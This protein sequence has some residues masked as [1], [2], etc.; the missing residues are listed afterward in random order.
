MI[1]TNDKNNCDYGIMSVS[2]FGPSYHCK[3]FSESFLIFVKLILAIFHQE[4]PRQ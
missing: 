2:S 4:P 3:I 1:F